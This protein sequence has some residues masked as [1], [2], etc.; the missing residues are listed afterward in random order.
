MRPLPTAVLALA[1]PLLVAGCDLFG[2]D[3]PAAVLRVTESQVTPEIVDVAEPR[4]ASRYA[5]FSVTA[6][7]ENRSSGDVYVKT[8]PT[9]FPAE[10]VREGETSQGGVLWECVSPVLTIPPRESAQRVQLYVRCIDGACAADGER[11][12]FEAGEYRLVGHYTTV[13]G[14]ADVPD[15]S[16]QRRA[17]SNRFRVAPSAALR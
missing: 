17:V 9:D 10:L 14:A 4:G 3:D 2:S 1:L 8:C 6:R 11:F 16:R 7:Y 12:Q 5:R 13:L 15:F